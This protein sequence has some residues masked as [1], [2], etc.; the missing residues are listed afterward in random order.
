MKL[1]VNWVGMS[2]WSLP[3]CP[4]CGSQVNNSCL[5]QCGGCGT[6]FYTCRERHLH[7]QRGCENCLRRYC[8]K[9]YAQHSCPGVDVD[10]TYSKRGWKELTPTTPTEYRAVR[11][12]ASTTRDG[13][14]QE[15]KRQRAKKRRARRRARAPVRPLESVKP[16]PQVP[17][18]PS[19]PERAVA[20][21]QGWPQDRE[22]PLS[23][24]GKVESTPGPVEMGR[25]PPK[26]GKFPVMAP[27]ITGQGRRGGPGDVQLQGFDLPRWVIEDPLL[28]VVKTREDGR[29]PVLVREVRADGAP[30][31]LFIACGMNPYLRK[32]VKDGNLQQGNSCYT[33]CDDVEDAEEDLEMDA[34]AVGEVVARADTHGAEGHRLRHWGCA[35]CRRYVRRALMLVLSNSDE[36]LDPPVFG[37]LAHGSMGDQLL[38]GGECRLCR[39]ACLTAV[40]V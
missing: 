9:G 29:R 18:G 7:F 24:G 8:E 28:L 3:D 31:R 10:A 15:R 40:G 34:G 16:S 33:L 21:G 1:V 39:N 13:L 6:S 22:V 37:S 23:G 32:L 36:G 30:K 35:E 25:I 4:M 2:E 20:W 27:M 5:S 11:L 14:E 26:L 38:H 12:Q 19:T 17:G